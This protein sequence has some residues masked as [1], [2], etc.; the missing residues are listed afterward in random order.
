MLFRYCK[1]NQIN[2]LFVA[3]TYDDQ[4]ET[5]LLRILRGSGIDGISGMSFCSVINNINIVRPLLIFKKEA[6]IQFLSQKNLIFFQDKSNQDMKFDRV[7]VR[8]FISQINKI[9]DNEIRIRL[10]CKAKDPIMSILIQ[11]VS[12]YFMPKCF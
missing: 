5:I 12:G 7:R 9:P 4:A 1:N 11:K 3:H 6:V 8:Y 2:D 10:L